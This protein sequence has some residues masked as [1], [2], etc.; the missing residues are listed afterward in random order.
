MDLEETLEYLNNPKNPTLDSLLVL[1]PPSSPNLT[2]IKLTLNE[3]PS[4]NIFKKLKTCKEWEEN[5]D[6]D[7]RS[8]NQDKIREENEVTLS[9]EVNGGNPDK[10]V[11]EETDLDRTPIIDKPYEHELENPTGRTKENDDMPHN[12]KGITVPELF[13]LK[14]LGN[15]SSSLVETPPVEETSPPGEETSLC[16]ETQPTETGTGTQPTEPQTQLFLVQFLA[17]SIKNTNNEIKEGEENCVD[18]EKK[19]KIC[20]EKLDEKE[21]DCVDLEEKQKIYQ[22]QLEEQEKEQEEQEKE[23]ERCERLISEMKLKFEQIELKLEQIELK[24]N[25]LKETK[26]REKNKLR[27][28]D[29]EKNELKETK[30]HGEKR[31]RD[32]EEATQDKKQKKEKLKK[33][34]TVELD[35]FKVEHE[36]KSQRNKDEA[37]RIEDE[38]RRIEDEAQ[39]IEDKAQRIA[40]ETQRIDDEAVL[41]ESLL[42]Q[43]DN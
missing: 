21:K 17:E 40:D 35:K 15:G 3:Q 28:I 38:V 11:N 14:L 10:E 32:T 20:Q 25:E 8:P 4:G 30:E 18:L 29:S 24:K 31:L 19:Q 37:Q 2:E 6:N 12:P 1:E 5:Q 39:R 41:L 34:Y 26:E 27:E 16:V 43:S 9:E 7:N 22:E 13:N 23:Q 42:F 36:E 33:D